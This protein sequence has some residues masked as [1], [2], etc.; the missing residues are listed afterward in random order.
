MR[1]LLAC[2]AMLSHIALAGEPMIVAHRAG[3]A[4]YPE[5]TLLAIRQS[6]AHG[7]DALWLSVQVS[8]DGV[9]VLY[10][11]QDLSALTPG[12]GPVA[13]HNAAQL[14]RLNAAW[15]FRRDDVGPAS[16]R[17]RRWH[18]EW[19]V[20][21]LDRALAIIPADVPI[22]LDMKSVPAAPLVAA[23]AE[24]LERRQAW[25]RVWLY[26]TDAAFNHHWQRYPRAQVMEARDATRARLLTLALAQRCEQAP[27]LP[28]WSAFELR[29]DLEVR[30]RFTLGEGLSPITAAQLWTPQA[31]QCF[32]SA[33][34]GVGVLWIGVASASDYQQA[35]KLG[36]DAVMVD[37]PEQAMQ[38][39]LVRAAAR[40]ANP[41][42][43]LPAR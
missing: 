11:P 5:N 15:T 13:A 14:A 25:R 20:P 29:R 26:S 42:V 38:W 34:A 9:P 30:E 7:T 33:H 37:S 35:V 2:V 28:T 12:H 1:W 4:D 43:L 23:V 22:F 3:T 39:K 32:R 18:P 41:G 17:Y 8:A 19:A 16:R 27:T 40:V 31:L 10:R 24:V 6:L 36:V 21:R